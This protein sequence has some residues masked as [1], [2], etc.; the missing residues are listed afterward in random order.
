[1]ISSK[2]YLQKTKPGHPLGQ[3][4]FVKKSHAYCFKDQQ[5][6]LENRHGMWNI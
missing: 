3:S 5:D 4:E 2:Y 1:M 6:D